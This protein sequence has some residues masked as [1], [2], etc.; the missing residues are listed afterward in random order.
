MNKRLAINTQ[1]RL[2]LTL[3]LLL[4]ACADDTYNAKQISRPDQAHYAKGIYVEPSPQKP[5]DAALG[6]QLLLNEAYVGCGIPAKAFPLLK[7]LTPA[8]FDETLP[9]RTGPAAEFPYSW[10]HHKTEAGVEL[11][12]PNCLLCHAGHFNGELMVGL[13]NVE[14]DFTA[15]FAIISKAVDLLA[16]VQDAMFDAGELAELQ[17]FTARIS[18][19]SSVTKMR[20]VGSNPANEIGV[21]LFS[22]RDPLTLAWS[23]EPLLE[24]PAEARIPVDVPPWWRMDDKSTM[25][26][27]GMGRGDHRNTLM[28]ASSLCVDDVAD[29]KK[30][31]S[32]F[33]HVAAYIRELPAP[34]YPF[35]IDR[36]QAQFG[37]AVFE[38]NC[39]GCHGSYG[40]GGNYPNLV[41]PI[42]VVDTDPIY[43][44]GGN[45]LG[46][47]IAWYNTSIY[48][49]DAWLEPITGYVAPPLD[50]IWATAPYLH[51][52]S[53]PTVA[54]LLD[55]DSRPR[56]WKRENYDSKNYDAAALGWPFIEMEYG[57]AKA[58]DAERKYIFDTTQVGH[59]NTG[60]RFGD[61]LTPK[62][63]RAVIEYLKTL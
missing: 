61:H 25:F 8:T 45:V 22:H 10:N 9:G 29:A 24:L 48:G 51:N 41:I 37:E 18:V 40:E 55:S 20:T 5:G 11:A 42:G 38:A 46:E 12:V 1:R 28:T 47:F 53:V 39:A 60:H 34:I 58:S 19:L 63:R 23:D 27:N 59:W 15:D 17:K 26:Y 30:I 50:G 21:L 49:A 52:G 44:F 57:Q 6:Y 54:A 62:E 2:W 7:H 32:Y 35:A 36:E 33:H 14:S 13:G 4:T 3:P 16:P 56:Y 43:A 31:D